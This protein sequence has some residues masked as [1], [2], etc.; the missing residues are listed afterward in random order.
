MWHWTGYIPMFFV[1]RFNRLQLGNSKK[2]QPYKQKIDL[3]KEAKTMFYSKDQTFI[4]TVVTLKHQIMMYSHFSKALLVKWF[5]LLF[6]WILSIFFR[7]ANRQ[8]NITKKLNPPSTYC[9]KG[10]PK[11]TSNV[12]FVKILPTLTK[13]NYFSTPDFHV[14]YV[15]FKA[16]KFSV[17]IENETSLLNLVIL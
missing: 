17:N 12:R 13:W 3:K 15:T 5:F 6:K 14:T 7:L 10:S 8:L 11:C 2:C 9:L 4:Y 16:I 1:R